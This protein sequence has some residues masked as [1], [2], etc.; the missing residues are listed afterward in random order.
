MLEMDGSWVGTK[1]KG[2]RNVNLLEKINE[3]FSNI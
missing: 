1:I 2:N 3:K